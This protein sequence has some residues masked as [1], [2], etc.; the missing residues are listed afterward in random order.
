MRISGAIS[1]A[2]VA[3][4]MQVIHLG[5]R[6][7]RLLLERGEHRAEID[8]V[9]G[10]V[11]GASSDQARPVAEI[12][13]ER[14][15]LTRPEL[16]EAYARLAAEPESSLD[17]AELLIST[18]RLKASQWS[19]ALL[20]RVESV[21]LDVVGWRAGTFAFEVAAE[22]PVATGQTSTSTATLLP[23]SDTQE[24]I[25]R[26]V[27]RQAFGRAPGEEHEDL[28]G[29]LAELRP[30]HP[31]SF[32]E[33]KPVVLVQVVSSDLA[34]TEEIAWRLG[35]EIRL[36]PVSLRDAGATP[37]GTDTVLVLLDLRNAVTLEELELV[38]RRRPKAI[39]IAI[40]PDFAAISD[41]VT[42]GAAIALPADAL[43]IA[44]CV[45]NLRSRSVG[46]PNPGTAKLAVGRILRFLDEI[47]SG[48]FSA[49]MS[50]SLMS[51]VSEYAERAVLL[52][53][54]GGLLH[55]VGAFGLRLPSEQ[56][57]ADGLRGFTVPLADAPGFRLA[58]ETRKVQRTPCVAESF[59]RGFLERVGVPAT[60]EGILIPVVG[61]SAV[62]SLVYAD[63]GPVAETIPDLD[64]VEIATSQAGLAFE[65]ELLQQRLEATPVLK[66]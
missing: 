7:G 66:R 4:V 54:R 27:R 5:G 21:V 36:S 3:E 2:G 52:V 39:S 33:H 40:A 11:V 37:P 28:S 10:R 16:L 65:S 62:F 55:A 18:E 51:I 32:T 13:I 20:E 53:P 46:E 41:A 12:L 29:G 25:L 56:P 60:G 34:L 43:A 9:L 59:T 35:E 42:H 1:D 57:I 15:E 24:L 47:R 19:N 6:S 17:L 45:R 49:T 8:F 58:L 61:R 44:S 48:V 64:V 63:N 26:A 30:P 31:Q 50:L 22:R 38:A 14:G 23:V